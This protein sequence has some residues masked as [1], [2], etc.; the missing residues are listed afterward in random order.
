[1]SN[2]NSFQLCDKISELDVNI[3]VC[4]IS[5]GEVNIEALR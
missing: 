3:R 2:M 1:M 4:F 5:A